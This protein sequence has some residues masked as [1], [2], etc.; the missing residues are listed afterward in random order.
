MR[1]FFIL[2]VCLCVCVCS[3]GE[4]ENLAEE[5]LV[6]KG[7]PELLDS[8]INGMVEKQ[9]QANPALIPCRMAVLEYCRRSLSFEVH[10]QALITLYAEKFT[11]DE[12][13]E[14]IRIA[15]TPLGKKLAAFDRELGLKLSS[16]NE[17]KLAENL[18]EFQKKLDNL[19]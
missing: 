16:W 9:I 10:K 14:L 6:A 3:A 12:L 8:T 11:A 17:Q 7:T 19:K 13:R 5:Y 15:R 1:T 4:K 18:P 2:A